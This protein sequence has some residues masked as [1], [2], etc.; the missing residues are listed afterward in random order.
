MCLGCLSAS[1]E[2][3]PLKIRR[4]H[5]TAV[6]HQLTLSLERSSNGAVPVAPQWRV[7]SHEAIQPTEG[8][9]AGG[10]QAAGDIASRQSRPSTEA[11]G[12]QQGAARSQAERCRDFAPHASQAASRRGAGADAAAA[13]A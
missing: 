8:A 12:R 3:H 2:P 7:N 13:A 6:P 4:R 5:T 11:R 1:V 9:Q 10:A